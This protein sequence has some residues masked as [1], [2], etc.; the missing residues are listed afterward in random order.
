MVLIVASQKGRTKRENRFQ[1]KMYQ[2]LTLYSL[3]Q[4]HVNQELLVRSVFPDI[5][6]VSPAYFIRI[7][8]PSACSE[9][10]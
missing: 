7:A 6:Q 9:T 4:V 10:E 8:R 3:A 5:V 1:P 2:D